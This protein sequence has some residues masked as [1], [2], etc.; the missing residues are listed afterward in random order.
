MATHRSSAVLRLCFALMAVL[1]V[2]RALPQQPS[3]KCRRKCG[4]IEIPYPFG[5]GHKAL[6]EHCA[7]PGLHVNCKDTGNGIH[8]PFIYDEVEVLSISV[9]Q[10]QVRVR[11]DMPSYCYN[12]SSHDMD[13]TNSWWS[14]DLTRSPYRFSDTGNRFTVVGCRALAYIG[15]EDNVNNYLSGCVSVCRQD[16]FRGE[17]TDG[18]CSGIGCC[19]T[20]IPKGLQ[21]YQVWF[22]YDFNTSEI[23]KTSRCNYA[24]LVEASNFSFSASYVTSSAFYDAYGGQPPLLLDWALGQHDSCAEAQRKPESFACVSSN[25]E[26]L[27]SSNGPGYICNCSKGF[28]GNPYLL[29]GCQGIFVCILVVLIAFLGKEWI[30]HKRRIKLQE[31]IRKMNEYFQENGGQLL[32]D[33]MRVESDISFKLYHREQIELATNNFDNSSIIGEGGQGTVYIGHNLDTDNNPVAIKICKGFDESRRL[34]FG[35]ELLILSRVKHDNIV[36]LIGCSL[37]FEAPVLVYEYVPNKTLHYLIH[38]QDE[39]SIRTLEIRVKIAAESAGAL[40][41]LH[42]LNHPIFHG[43]VKSVNILLSHDLSA[44]VSDFGCSMIRSTNEN[45]QVVKGTMGYLDPEY[46]LNFELTD[47]SDVYSFG[48]VLLELLM[49]KTALSKNKESIVSVFKEAVEEGRLGEV[50]DREIAEQDNMEFV[51]QVAELA[52]KCLIMTRQHRPTM[53]NVAEE[54]WQLVALLRQHTGEIHGIS[55]LTLQGRL[56]TN[57]SVDNIIWEEGSDQY[58]FQNKTSMSI[59]IVKR[60]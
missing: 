9:P 60:N 34:E 45:A 10:A 26:C 12:T 51:C 47:K 32:I 54:L 57:M 28:Q 33:M 5:I 43:D 35:K 56:S 14:L 6:P 2:A 49:R 20:A 50:V 39:A 7:W 30:K 27:N 4:Q 46:L 37:Q 55:P 59:E 42:S 15:Y 31:H 53:S 19:Q 52:G 38:S 17:L 48:V 24:A 18:S 23:Y 3:S 25:S 44:K 22:N 58:N 40:A 11:M 21:Y 8:K 36:K 1:P 16:H 41:Y 13:D 29:D